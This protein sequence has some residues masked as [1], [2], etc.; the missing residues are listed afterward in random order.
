MEALMSAASTEA[1]D[2]AG[3]TGQLRLRG[4]L[5]TLITQITAKIL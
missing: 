1:T 4:N 5:M 3:L 2:P